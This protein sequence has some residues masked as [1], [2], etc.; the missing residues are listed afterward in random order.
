M[1]LFA[2]YHVRVYAPTGLIPQ[3]DEKLERFAEVI[4]DAV[5]AGVAAAQTQIEERLSPDVRVQVNE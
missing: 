3:A 2:E 1:T 5:Y 4:E